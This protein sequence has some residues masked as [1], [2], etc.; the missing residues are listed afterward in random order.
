[1]F[2]LSVETSSQ[3]GSLA[4]IEST[5]SSGARVLASTQWSKSKSHS[6]VITVKLDECLSKA[7]LELSGITHLAVGQGPGSFTGLRVG[8]NL[9]RTL[10]YANDLPVYSCSSLD[11]LAR[12]AMVKFPDKP[13]L[14]LINA[15]RNLMYASCYQSVDSTHSTHKLVW[16]P[17]AITVKQ[18]EERIKSSHTC[19]GNGY[20]TFG[21][22]LSA[23]LKSWLDRD[24]GL[25]DTPSATDLGLMAVDPQLKNEF[26]SWKSI[27]PLYIR[28]SEA[29]EK[30]RSGLLKPIREI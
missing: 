3:L 22:W 30:L 2:L 28:G 14:C 26:S 18:L 6:E 27:K 29:E 7:G 5:S 10:G 8:I 11:V 13:V 24:E 12:P 4:I 23:P 15:F 21:N 9:V 25:E 1:M 17:E 16:G 20:E 19:V